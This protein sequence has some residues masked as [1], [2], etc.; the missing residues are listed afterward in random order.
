MLVA[1]KA[2]ESGTIK[3]QR[4]TPQKEGCKGMGFFVLLLLLLFLTQSKGERAL[5]ALY[6]VVSEKCFV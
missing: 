5:A 3:N 4:P 6:Q 2:V 1:N